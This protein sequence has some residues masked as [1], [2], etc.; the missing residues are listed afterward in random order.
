[1]WGVRFISLDFII[2]LNLWMFAPQTYW[3]GR[4]QGDFW[5][6]IYRWTKYTL[7]KCGDTFSVC[8]NRCN[9]DKV[10]NGFCLLIRVRG[11]PAPC[12]IFSS[13]FIIPRFAQRTFP[14][15]NIDGS[16]KP[17]FMWSESAAANRW[18]FSL[19]LKG[20]RKKCID[21]NADISK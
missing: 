3:M 14:G 1:M 21:T 17:A 2:L 11:T 5:G 18:P 16:L 13:C 10:W 6:N 9:A 19:P 15:I 4:I 7:N 8:Q 20:S 12:L